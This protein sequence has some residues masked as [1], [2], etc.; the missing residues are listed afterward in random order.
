ML[1][2]GFSTGA[3]AKGDVEQGIEMVRR[4]S[5][6]AIELSALRVNE[7]DALEH[8]IEFCDLTPFR[9]VSIHAPTNYVAD[10]ELSV[11]S[12]LA[13][14]AAT[15]KWC[16][17]VH[18]DCI[19]NKNAWSGL[20]SYL[21][22]ENMDKRKTVGRTADELASWFAEFP[23]ARLCFDIAHAQQVD[24]SMTEAYQILRRFRHRICQLHVSE[25]T[26]SSTHDRL[27]EGAIRAF[28]EVAE[29]LPLDAPIIL[30]SPVDEHDA[31][32]EIHQAGR[33]FEHLLN[34]A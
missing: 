4:L 23:Q 15:K 7:L 21:C 27:S 12:R 9:Y 2:T 22:I 24:P 8:A 32:A 33:I 30:E 10:D 26:S 6:D 20:G 19:V 5:L 11:A 1:T 16:V 28:S 18:P 29:D 34:L 13:D 14:I 3:L 25:V 17:V 31:V